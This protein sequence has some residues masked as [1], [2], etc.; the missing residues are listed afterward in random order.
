M[1]AT[2]NRFLDCQACDFAFPAIDNAQEC[3]HS[4]PPD[5]QISD[6]IIVPF[7]AADPFDWTGTNPAYVPG[8]IDNTVSSLAYARRL[9]GEG[10]VEVPE[11]NIITLPR[12]RQS[13]ERRVYALNF[14]VFNLEG[15]QY[16]LCKRFQQ[17]WQGFMFYFLTVGGK[18]IGLPGGMRPLFTDCDLPL[19]SSR[20]GKEYADILIEWDTDGEANRYSGRVSDSDVPEAVLE[21]WTECAGCDFCFPPVNNTQDCTSYPRRDS[22]VSEVIF[23][24][25][26]ANDPFEWTTGAP[27]LTSNGIDNDDPSME[28]SKRIVGEGGVEVLEKNIITL[29]RNRRNVERRVYTLRLRIRNTSSAQFAFVRK[30]QCNYKLFRFYY[31]TNGGRMF[32]PRGGIKPLFVDADFPLEGAR[33]AKEYFDLIIQWEDLGDPRRWNFVIS[34]QVVNVVPDVMGD[35]DAGD[36]T[37]DVWGWDE[38]EVW[39]L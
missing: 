16:E 11:K 28:V 4:I 10:A 25:I 7:A 30:F 23:R 18:L 1:G 24:P 32:G 8:T 21:E 38:N 31:L 13:V 33:G 26:Q 17:N 14:R 27:V 39:G 6:L 36:G 3:Y 34:D 2:L 12:N 19:D 37:G 29:P 35:P 20:L 22:Q 9:T 15:N 5:S